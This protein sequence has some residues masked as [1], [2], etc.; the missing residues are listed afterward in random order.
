MITTTI[1]A[2]DL[3]TAIPSLWNDFRYPAAILLI[4]A[5]VVAAIVSIHK[6]FGAAAG[7]LLGAIALAAITLGA[8]GLTV[9]FEQTVNRHGGNVL[10]GQY[11]Q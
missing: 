3:L 6:G 5:G 10:T 7:K 9:S 8:V 11:G 2:G 4:M 1:A